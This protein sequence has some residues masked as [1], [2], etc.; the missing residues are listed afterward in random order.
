MVGIAEN[1]KLNDRLHLDVQYETLIKDGIILSLS[2]I[3]FRILY[4]LTMNRNRIV[5]FDK[6]I[7]FAWKWSSTVTRRELYVYITR[8]R[9]KLD[10]NLK[11]I[12][13]RNRGYMMTE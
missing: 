13:V 5:S 2:K 11:I 7:D 8:L 12:C 3:E 9:K 6:L 10:D 4:C 1:L